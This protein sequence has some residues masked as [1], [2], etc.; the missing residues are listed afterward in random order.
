MRSPADPQEARIEAKAF[1]GATASAPAAWCWVS[2][3]KDSWTAYAVGPGQVS[4]RVA[5]YTGVSKAPTGE[6][7]IK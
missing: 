1:R 3:G 4:I 2:S 7:A 6:P 5:E